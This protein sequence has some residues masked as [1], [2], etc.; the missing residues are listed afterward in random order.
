[1]AVG[2][3][4]YAI[5]RHRILI[6]NSVRGWWTWFKQ[7]LGWGERV[8]PTGPQPNQA[9][10][11]LLRNRAFQRFA[12][13]PATCDEITGKLLDATGHAGRELVINPPPGSGAVVYPTKLGP[14]RSNFHSVYT[15]GN[16]VF[17]PGYRDTPILLGEWQA[18]VNKLNGG[19]NMFPD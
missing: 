7:W 10:L 14:A 17:D 5:G 4:S 13:G 11:R 1:M 12:D 6:H 15:D 8:V 9:A 16:F 3:P 2:L 18:E 19:I